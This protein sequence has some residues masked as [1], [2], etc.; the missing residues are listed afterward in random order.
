MANLLEISKLSYGYLEKAIVKNISFKMATH[1][2]LG[3]LGESGSGKSTLLKLI[4]GRL[5]PWSGELRLNNQL[6]NDGTSSL[7]AQYEGISLVDQDSDLMPY[8]SIDDNILQRSLHLAPSAR[9]R[10]LGHF[11]SR[12]KTSAIRS[13]KAGDVSGGQQ[14]RAALARAIATKPE[15]LLLDEPF[16]NLDYPLKR[17]I[18]ELLKTEWK[19]GGIVMVTHDPQD[20]MSLADRILVL[21]SGRVVQSGTAEEIYYHPKNEYVAGL[22]GEFNELTS[23]EMDK[24]K[25]LEEEGRFFRPVQFSI[26]KSGLPVEVTRVEFN[27]SSYRLY[28]RSQLSGSSIICD[29]HPSVKLPVIGDKIFLGVYKK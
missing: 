2:V 16:A 28:C 7:I 20:L 17:N 1:E 13:Q 25:L 27:G 23:E 22:L 4:G 12:L 19:T 5:D 14:S 24:L 10:L 21:K 26:S 15:L 6:L 18:I 11:H 9:K 8:L 29:L 3:I